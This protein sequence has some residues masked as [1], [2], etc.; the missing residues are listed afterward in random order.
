MSGGQQVSDMG[1][2]WPG[3]GIGRRLVA[4]SQR[5]SQDGAGDYVGGEL[6]QGFVF[7]RLLPPSPKQWGATYGSLMREA[8]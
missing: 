7:S 5:E 4:G 1:K 2:I 3:T 8:T 6:L